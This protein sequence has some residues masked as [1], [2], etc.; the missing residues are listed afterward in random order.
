MTKPRYARQGC[1]AGSQELGD[2]SSP[3]YAWGVNLNNGNANINNRNNDGLALPVSPLVA[4]AGECQSAEAITLRELYAAWREARRGKVPSCNQARFEAD[5]CERLIELQD[6]INSGIWSPRPTTCFIAQQPKAREI[7]AP[8]FADRVVHH[9]LVPKLEAIYESR[10]IA[11]SYANRTGKGTHAAVARVRSFARQVH[12]GQGGGWYL[13]L[14][15][16]NFFNSIHRPTLWALLKR[17][18]QRAHMPILQQR[19]THA[20]LR[21]SPLQQG[22]SHRSTAAERARVPPHKR[23]ENAPADCG[24]AIG[25]LSSQFFANVY[26]DQLDQFVKHTLRASRYVRFADDFVLI[27]QSR[28]QLEQWRDAIA[29]FLRT[30]LRLALKADQKLQPLTAG[31][32]FLGFVV[33][34]T[35]T[36]VRRRVVSHARAA[37]S[38]WETEHFAGETITATP[39]ALE[40]GRSIWASYCGHFAHA[41]A[42]RLE[43]RFRR[44]FRW[45]HAVE[46]KRRFPIAALGERIR[47]A[48]H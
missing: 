28:D 3:D 32:D 25:N 22:V 31:I 11:D 42:R 8:D 43:Q 21:R 13:Q 44:R 29:D 47:I 1:A 15:V 24:L 14:D 40:R 7:H 20:L 19:L 41:N 10:F 6:V 37:L 46:T 16:R 2:T 36:R 27:H 45:L 33:Y 30:R 17:Q 5:W 48:V 39:V 23:L 4:P 38:A 9:Y 35:H 34:P 26:L 12:S 18:M